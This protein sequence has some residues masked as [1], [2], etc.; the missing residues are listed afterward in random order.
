MMRP[1]MSFHPHSSVYE[2]C[3]LCGRRCGVDRNAGGAGFCGE[4]AELRIATASLHRGEEPPITGLGGSGTVF[5]T[6]CT[7]GCSFCQNRQI[8]REGMGAPVDAAS[9]AEIC[10]AL[11]K[12]GAENVNIVTGSHAAA[13]IAD[14]LRDARRRGLSIPALWNSSAYES[15]EAIDLAA[16]QIQV[17]LPDLKTLD[18][19]IS[20]RYFKAA[21]YPQAATAAILRMAELRPLR[22]APARGPLAAGMEEEDRPDVLVSGTVVRHLILPGQLE[23]TRNVLRWFSDKLGDRALLSLMTQYTPVKGS[24]GAEIPDRYIDQKEY[25]RAIELLEE[26]GIE[27]GFYQELVVSDDWLPDFSR[28]NPFSSELSV[29]VWHWRTG[30][31]H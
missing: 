27:N 6:G 28:T 24:D 13:A 2:H 12:A 29:P 1:M 14:G 18:P 9:F 16:D 17:Y 4:S 10:L 3:E 26:F 25:D 22:Y 30:F 31:I 11:E 5:V 19:A 21:D 8:S 20:K 7:L 15:T 23:D